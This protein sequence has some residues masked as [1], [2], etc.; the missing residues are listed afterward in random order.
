MSKPKGAVVY[1]RV[2]DL[3]SEDVASVVSAIRADLDD[4]S[5]RTYRRTVSADG[6]STEVVVVI[7][8]ERVGG[9][10]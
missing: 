9:G 6:Y 3:D 7:V 10:Q 1:S 5:V 4:C 8:R 2:L